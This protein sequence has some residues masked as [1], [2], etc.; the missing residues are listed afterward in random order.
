MVKPTVVVTA[1]AC[2]D[3]RTGAGEPIVRFSTSGGEHPLRGVG[4]T[5]RC[6]RA[7]TDAVHQYTNLAVVKSASRYPAA[8][9]YHVVGSPTP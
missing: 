5:R 1:V 8:R 7:V 4:T 6:C 3:A 2:A 9:L